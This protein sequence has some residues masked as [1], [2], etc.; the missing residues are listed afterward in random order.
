MR[1]FQTTFRGLGS[2]LAPNF[3]RGGLERLEGL[4]FHGSSSRWKTFP[5]CSNLNY[6]RLRIYSTWRSR[7]IQVMD[8]QRPV[9]MRRRKNIAPSGRGA[10]PTRCQMKETEP[11]NS[12]FPAG[13]RLAV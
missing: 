4:Q 11:M 1:T 7:S 10:F 5:A 13:A 8:R 9:L 3:D 6:Y 12:H 2:K